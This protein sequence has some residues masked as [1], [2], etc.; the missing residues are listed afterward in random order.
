MATGDPGQAG[1]DATSES[2]LPRKGVQLRGL[3]LRCDRVLGKLE[4]TLG[5]GMKVWG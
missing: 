2:L 4:P 1:E 3:Y 5:S